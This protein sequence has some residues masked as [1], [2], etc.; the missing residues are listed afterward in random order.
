V[1]V[2]ELGPASYN[3]RN[4]SKS[5]LATLKKSMERF[6]DLSGIVYNVRTK[7]LVG[8]HQRL[9]NFDPEWTISITGVRAKRPVDK[10][11]TVA[12]GYV[13]APSGQWTYR[14]V[15]WDEATEKAANIAANAAGGAF[16]DDKL[17][18]LVIEL[19]EAG[20]DLELLNLDDL[21][22]ILG[23]QDIDEPTD[24]VPTV[25]TKPR[26]K[27]GYLYELGDHRIMCGDS[28]KSKDV[29]RL[30]R[31]EAAAMVFTDPPYGVSYKG[32]G[33]DVIEGDRKRDDELIAMLSDALK[34]AAAHT[35]EGAAFY[36]WHASST[37][38]DFAYALKSAGLVERQYLIWAKPHIVLGRADYHW[39]HEP[40]FYASKCGCKPEFYGDRAQPTVWRI[41][42]RKRKALT[43]ILGQGLIVRAQASGNSIVIIPRAPKSKKIRGLR[44]EHGQ[45]A[46]V[47]SNPS[48]GDIW[49]VGADHG[50]VHPTQKPVELARRAIMNSSRE[51]Q[52]VYDAF[53]GS[54]STLIAA[55]ATKRRALLM[56]LDPKYV[57][58]IISR[59][60]ILTGRKAQLVDK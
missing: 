19:D 22:S 28:T 26:S 14:E 24:E 49:D 17:K 29:E 12:R 58:V 44:L 8:G 46:F 31:N 52:I 57:D 59:W 54:G 39:A 45:S 4:I 23:K 37:R 36:I 41:T 56:E 11:G 30:F 15:D 42:E 47:D 38:E 5:R 2:K 53:G 48:G 1:K 50:Y 13:S 27:R 55:E 9:K 3:P 25:P 10:A 35:D 33:F 51:G 16:D 7:R 60:E 6:G 20:F 32:A 18:G 40:C 34:Q 43:T 21:E